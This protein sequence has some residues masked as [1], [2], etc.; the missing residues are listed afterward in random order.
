MAPSFSG[1]FESRHT[2]HEEFGMYAL[3]RR[4]ADVRL[5]AAAAMMLGLAAGCIIPGVNDATDEGGTDTAGRAQLL[6]APQRIAPVAEKDLPTAV[7]GLTWSAVTG[8]TQYDVYFGADPNPPL[9][10]SVTT[11]SYNLFRL[12]ECE[13]QYWRVV[14]RTGTQ[15]I[16][17]P[18][19]KFQTRCP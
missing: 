16:S 2:R 7:L 12:P 11:T 17:S 14:A 19:W 3:M 1:E 6:I 4:F 15:S 10:A 8:A 13:T 9:L 5:V 18:T